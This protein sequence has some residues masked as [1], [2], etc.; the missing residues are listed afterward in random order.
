MYSKF[1]TQRIPSGITVIKP[2]ELDKVFMKKIDLS[3]YKVIHHVGDIHGCNTALQKY[4]NAISGIK[5][6]H[7]FIFCGDY[8]DRG[9]ENAEV[10]QFLLSIKDKPN[11]L[12]LEGNHEIHLVKIRSHSQKNLNYLQNLH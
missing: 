3:E 5:D 10:V 6:D 4:L 9:I 7:F 12:L 2:E 11:V 1:K 8:I